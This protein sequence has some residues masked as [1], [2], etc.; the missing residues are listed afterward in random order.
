MSKID[1]KVRVFDE[2]LNIIKEIT[3]TILLDDG[4]TETEISRVKIG[5]RS[6]HSDYWR[7]H[8]D[9]LQEKPEG[10]SEE[11]YLIN[12][13]IHEVARIANAFD[14][15]IELGYKTPENAVNVLNKNQ[16]L[17]DPALAI[18]DKDSGAKV[19][20]FS[21]E[22]LLG[23]A[24]RKQNAK[25]KQDYSRHLH[26]A[27]DDKSSQVDRATSLLYLAMEADAA[28]EYIKD[29]APGFVGYAHS[30]A[31]YYV[32][33]EGSAF[34]Q[35]QFADGIPNSSY[36]FAALI[37]E[38]DTFGSNPLN[39]GKFNASAKSILE[40]VR[41]LPNSEMRLKAAKQISAKYLA[42]TGGG[43]SIKGNNSPL[44]SDLIESYK[45]SLDMDLMEEMLSSASM[46]G[47][48]AE[49]SAL[50]SN[51]G[52]CLGSLKPKPIYDILK[53]Q[54]FDGLVESPK[55][56]VIDD[57]DNSQIDEYADVLYL[58][59]KNEVSSIS[60]SIEESLEILNH[61]SKSWNEY[62]LRRGDL[63]EGALH[64]LSEDSDNV[65][66]KVENMP[67]IKIQISLLIDESG[68]MCCFSS[69][70]PKIDISKTKIF[71]ETYLS[72]IG[73]A[74]KLAVA[75][76]EG[77]KNISGAD[78]FVYGHAGPEPTC[79]VY[80]YTN[81]N[82]VESDF[83]R[84]SYI[85]D[86][87]HNYDGFAILKSGED[88]LESEIEY[89]RR[90]MFVLSDGEP[91]VANY[92]GVESQKHIKSVVKYLNDEGIEVY[93][94]GIDDAFPSDAANDMYGEGNYVILPEFDLSK[95]ATIISSFLEEVCRDD[96]SY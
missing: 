10:L 5:E 76:Q 49:S 34:L 3:K 96:R 68:S 14:S 28:C 90:I 60:S 29:N 32:S 81:P 8:Y 75:F 93:V 16:V 18:S 86:R 52:S 51:D 95:V 82:T 66:Y 35:E 53:E 2:G 72:R 42:N 58:E 1:T 20:V 38:F 83:S 22:I 43:K 84:L 79:H 33:S 25:T 88:M 46:L 50:I 21:G 13:C 63:D 12:K 65:F 69:E 59:T 41:S 7:D 40:Q 64:K 24:I 31:D 54:I 45:D 57:L 71:G 78:L 6:H 27:F 55:I 70:D 80:R 62:A 44:G 36:K 89:N 48:P 56:K 73:V 17:L 67:K 94:I 23:T 87:L 26:Q 85:T 92:N 47:K 19:D 39:Y 74:Q 61:D 4:S 9:T 30:R 15:S 77:T 37:R 91:S 11:K